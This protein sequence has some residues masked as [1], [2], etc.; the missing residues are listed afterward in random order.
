M[1]FL[2]SSVK[3]VV[4]FSIFALLGVGISCV[5]AGC[6]QCECPEYDRIEPGQYV[7]ESGG[8]ASTSQFPFMENGTATVSEQQVEIEFRSSDIDWNIIFNIIP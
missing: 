8:C 1:T 6:I 4:S 5:V 7:L 2:S 3:A